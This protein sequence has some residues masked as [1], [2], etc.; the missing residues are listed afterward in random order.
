MKQKEELKDSY[1]IKISDEYELKKIYI[2]C[3]KDTPLFVVKNMVTKRINPGFSVLLFVNNMLL[4][5]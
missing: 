1:I 5:D 3:H 2:C 4:N